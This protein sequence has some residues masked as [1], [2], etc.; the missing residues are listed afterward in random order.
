MYIKF[1]YNSFQGMRAFLE[2][3][4]ITEIILTMT[5]AISFSS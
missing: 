3:A 5:P 1:M 4:P 2:A